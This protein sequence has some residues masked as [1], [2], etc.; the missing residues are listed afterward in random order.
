MRKFL[1]KPKE[2]DLEDKILSVLSTFIEIRNEI[3]EVIL[4]RDVTAEKRDAVVKLA[5]ATAH[6]LRQPLQIIVGTLSL[7]RDTLKDNDGIKEYI[8]IIEKSCY[9]MN[10]IIEKIGRAA[11]YKTQVYSDGSKMFDIDKSSEG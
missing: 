2:L 11:K 8:D 6:E 7:I 4:F 1:E 5:G 9:R 10:D 3:W